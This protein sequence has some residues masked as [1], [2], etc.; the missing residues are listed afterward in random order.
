[1]METSDDEDEFY[2]RT[3]VSKKNDSKQN[4]DIETAESLQTRKDALES[5]RSSLLLQLKRLNSSGSSDPGNADSLDSFMSDLSSSLQKEKNEKLQYELKNVESALEKAS[6]LLSISKP[7]LEG[8]KKRIP[9]DLKRIEES[10]KPKTTQG[11]IATQ[12]KSTDKE[13]AEITQNETDNKEKDEPNLLEGEAEKAN[14]KKIKKLKKQKIEEEE[15]VPQSYDDEVDYSDW[16][17][18]ADQKGDGKTRL[19]AL[20]GY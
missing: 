6:K 9:T 14:K 10:K 5:Q 19:N 13:I 20:Y 4:R 1:V 7:A 18:P 17:P 16:V 15:S 3:K 2:D 11:L 8:L 12:I